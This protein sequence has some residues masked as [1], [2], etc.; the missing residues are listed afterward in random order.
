M[1]ETTCDTCGAT[2]AIADWPWC[3]HGPSSLVTVPDDIPGGL[4]VSNLGPHPITVYS[5]SER[6]RIMR[7]RGLIE[8]VEHVPGDRYV[9]RMV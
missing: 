2:Y 5:H 6:K 3:P 1:I 8:R 9:G 7:S 4:K